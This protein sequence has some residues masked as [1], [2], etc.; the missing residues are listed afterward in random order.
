LDEWVLSDEI[1][2]AAH[3]WPLILLFILVGSLLGWG[4][5]YLLPSPYQ[6]SEEISVEL[7]AYRAAEDRYAADYADAE[8]RNL[9][10][11][12]H[13]QMSQL[14]VLVRSDA[15]LQETLNRLRQADPAWNTVESPDLRNMLKAYWRNAGRWRLTAENPNPGQARQAVQVWKDVILEKTGAAVESSQS[16]FGTELRLRALASVLQSVQE[17]LSFLPEI[18]SALVDWRLA[19]SQLPADRPLGP[20]DRWHLQALAS[21]AAGPETNWQ[22]LMAEFPSSAAP[23]SNYQSWIDRLMIAVDEETNV[24]AE[25]NQFLEA[26]QADLMAQWESAIPAGQGLSATLIVDPVSTER[27]QVRQLR[28][29]SQAAL[30]GGLLGLLAWALLVVYQITRRAYR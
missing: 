10:D 17:R 16:L 24:L 22:E 13:W 14:E 8:F 30:V 18:R 19:A 12:K 28:S 26:E 3:R 1:Y 11:Y 23:L 27:P 4:F 29:T 7:N 25:R 15:Y 9:D 21:R 20:V 2:K 5:S 6:A